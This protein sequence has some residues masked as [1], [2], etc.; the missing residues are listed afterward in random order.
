M[1]CSN[2]RALAWESRTGLD[3]WLAGYGGCYRMVFDLDRSVTCIGV[4]NIG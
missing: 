3:D 1:V 4:Y 2:T